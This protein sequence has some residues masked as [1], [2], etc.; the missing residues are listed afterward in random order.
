MLTFSL[1]I[2]LI[3]DRTFDDLQTY[4]SYRWLGNYYRWLVEN[5][6]IDRLGFWVANGV[7][8]LSILLLVG[9]LNSLF[10]NALFG[11][12][13]LAFYV[14]IAALCLG[15]RGLDRDIDEYIDSLGMD[16]PDRLNRAS[17]SLGVDTVSSNQVE[18]VGQVA[19]SIFV[20][21]NRGHYS[22]IFWMVLAGPV[23]AVGYRLL[24]RLAMQNELSVRPDWKRQA[25]QLVAWMEWIPALL[26]SYAFMI[27]GSFEAGLNRNQQFPVFGGDLAD[28]NDRR[29]R[30][31][32]LASTGMDALGEVLDSVEMIKKVRGLVLRSLVA[33]IAFGA[34]VE[35]WT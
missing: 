6:K 5:W 19:G 9:L 32:G 16:D 23:A 33:W 1:I 27:C 31:V 28:I 10:H 3:L 26:S 2:A 21:A 22:V 11:L 24:E 34:L 15:P 18:A 4:R 7:L 25:T 17:A 13:E 14:V 20:I 8:L 12:F 35:Y 30:Q 29:L